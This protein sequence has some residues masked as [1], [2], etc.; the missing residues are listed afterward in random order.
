MNVVHCFSCAHALLS[1][2]T[3]PLLPLLCPTLSLSHTRSLSSSRLNV[4]PPATATS[5]AP[6]LTSVSSTYTQLPTSALHLS[7]SLCSSRSGA[8]VN[9]NTMHRLQTHY[10]APLSV[11]A[12]GG[13][14]FRTGGFGISP[15]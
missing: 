8:N 3:V 4:V 13:L 10:D 5:P 7:F 2:G 14:R 15:A 12:G 6:S 11:A 9:A 1:L